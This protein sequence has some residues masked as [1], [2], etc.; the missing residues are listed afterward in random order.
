MKSDTT[1][2]IAA[3]A[4]AATIYAFTGVFIRFL[5]DLGLNVYTVNFGELIIGL[6]LILLAARLG[7]EKIERPTGQEWLWLSLIGLCQ[8]GATVALFHAY[9]TT[10]IANVEFLHYTFPLLTAVGAALFLKER[11]D[12]SKLIA[13]VL[14]AVGLALVLNPELALD[15]QMRLGNTLAFASAFPVATIALLGRKLKD[16][17]AYFTAFWS[18]LT[19]AIVYAPFFLLHGS[20]SGLENFPP[21]S[22]G[23]LVQGLK[24]IGSIALVSLLFIGIA[25]PLYYAGLRHLE[26]SKAGVLLLA[27]VVVAV[28]IGSVLY[29]EIPTALNVF[30][31]LLILASGIIILQDKPRRR[32]SMTRIYR[33]AHALYQI[34]YHF[35][36]VPKHRGALLVDRVA[37]KIQSVLAEV[38]VQYDLEIGQMEVQESHV[39]VEVSAP[40]KYAPAEI[41]H[42]LK[43]I[44]AR[45]TF[46]A[47]PQ[48]KENLWAG[49]LWADGYYV[50]TSG[51]GLSPQVIA[52][53]AQYQPYQRLLEPMGLDHPPHLETGRSG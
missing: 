53:Y 1:K 3:I 20:I 38:A 51:N 49:E 11:L 36:W 21:D 15:R 32:E 48:L 17:P 12:K 29:K 31:G 9:N 6:P 40:P 42:W 35:V 44:S 23:A 19:A 24:Q 37:A 47:F 5:T 22:P 25:A 4:A 10:T 30:G 13:L 14:S 39:H 46:A 16:R 43:D 27:E 52:E 28:I 18:T 34:K 2:G 8:F 26:A 50:S 41:V 7:R 45:E 33:S